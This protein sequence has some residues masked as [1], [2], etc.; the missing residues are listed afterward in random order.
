MRPFLF[1][2]SIL[3]VAPVLAQPGFSEEEKEVYDVIIKL[4][5]GIRTG[6]SSMVRSAFMPGAKMYTA[7][8]D[9]EGKPVLHEGNLDKFVEFIGTPHDKV[10]DE[11]VWNTSVKIDGPLAQVWTDY[12]FYLGDQFSHC[13]VDAFELFKTDKGWKIFVITDTRRKEGC[14]LPEELKNR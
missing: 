12:A 5:E 1:I 8:F 9:K 13:G 10:Y 2:L 3:C 14:E 6:D 11:P 4:F 7:T